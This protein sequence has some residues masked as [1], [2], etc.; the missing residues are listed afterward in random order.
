MGFQPV[1]R[2]LD[3][4]SSGDTQIP[5]QS[6]FLVDEGGNLKILGSIS[7]SVGGGGAGINFSNA[8]FTGIVKVHGSGSVILQK[9]TIIASETNSRVFINS[10]QGSAINSFKS[11]SDKVSNAIGSLVDMSNGFPTD[12][13]G[14][15]LGTIRATAEDAGGFSNFGPAGDY[16]KKASNAVGQ[17]TNAVSGAVGQ[18]TGAASGIVNQVKGIGNVFNDEAIIEEDD[19][20]FRGIEEIYNPVVGYPEDAPN[21]I[22]AYD[23]PV[24]SET[25]DVYI[26]LEL[27][28]GTID[29]PSPPKVS[30][31]IENPPPGISINEHTG[32]V[33]G[34]M[35][36]GSYRTNVIAKDAITNKVLDIKIYSIR[37]IN[38]GFYSE[39]AEDAEDSGT[40]VGGI[41]LQGPMVSGSYRQGSKYG[42]RHHPI[43]KS[44]RMHHGVDMP[45]PSGTPVGASANG[46]V[47]YAGWKNGYGNIV[48]IGH[49]NDAGQKVA[50]TRYAH[51]KNGTLAVKQGQEVT[52]GQIIGGVGTT[53]GSTGNH[54]H[55]EVRERKSNGTFAS[56]DPA[57]IAYG[58]H[59]ITIDGKGDHGTAIAGG[60]CGEGNGDPTADVVNEAPAAA[61]DYLT[62]SEPEDENF[63]SRPDV[64]NIM[65][66]VFDRHPELDNM[67]RTYL[68][69]VARIESQFDPWCKDQMSSRTGLFQMCDVVAYA[70]PHDRNDVESSTEAMIQFYLREEKIYWDFFI[71]TL[72]V[73]I[74]PHLVI[75][76]RAAEIYKTYTKLE[77][78]YGLV[79]HDGV[80][81]ARKGI[82]QG[83]VAYLQRMM[84]TFPIEAD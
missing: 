59:P 30:W 63:I 12:G 1:I 2:G 55:F 62:F 36:V 81:N 4:D 78:I 21:I 69:F 28:A 14:A 84:K 45:A 48:Q 19:Y 11:L 64:I 57:G 41:Q 15:L 58:D 60:D 42:M 29:E 26:Q 44:S 56:I 10:P 53:G 32:E 61:A 68:F 74:A 7:E 18:M 70:Y 72:G 35:A 16:I 33:S 67:D 13:A 22:T 5:T 38:V 3:K 8:D 31:S 65:N 25:G 23:I 27:G 24:N 54:L 51:L 43:H 50:E 46:K 37:R 9:G 73:R 71:K 75:E 17:V 76:P 80:E 52:S 66:N 49:Y 79:H 82:S 39:D 6:N 77:F 20:D 47:E 40:S 34:N 83:G